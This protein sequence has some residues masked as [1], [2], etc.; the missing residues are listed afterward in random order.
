[1]G[2]GRL[3]RPLLRA[4]GELTTRR[5]GLVLVA[6]AGLSAAA[7]A[8][9]VDLPLD[10]SFMAM[11]PQDD[12]RVERFKDATGSFGGSQN[13]LLLV[14]GAPADRDGFFADLRGR[15]ATVEEVA[16]VDDRAAA[17]ALDPT[18]DAVR[19]RPKDLAGLA[20]LVRREPELARRLTADP[21]LA[22]LLEV[23]LA[24]APR[25][26]AGGAEA[27]ELPIGPA[28]LLGGLADAAEGR[29]VVPA[30][31]L[32]GD[33]PDLDARGRLVSADGR[34]NLAVVRLAID[35]LEMEVGGTAYEGI[36]DAT[37]AV[38]AGYPD[39]RWGYAGAIPFGYEDE[40]SV[41]TRIRWIS[42][43]SLGL[44]LLLFLWVER[45]PLIALLIAVPMALGLLWTFALVRLVLGV[46]TLTSAVFA[47]LLFGLAVDFAIHLVA[48]VH[49][50]E[51][52]GEA[53]DHRAAVRAALARTG[54][55]ILTGGLTTA[56][57]FLALLAGRQP[58]AR[59]LGFTTGVG[60]L[61]SLAA[62]LVVLPAL[63]ALA[64]RWRAR[65][66]GMRLPRLDGWVRVCL[67]RPR[68]VAG[69]V[70]ALTATAVA[71]IP[72][73]R[74]EYDIEAMATRGT[75]AA[76]VGREV[77]ERFGVSSDYGLCVCPDLATAEEVAAALRRSEQVARVEA[78]TDVL[79]TDP[80]AAQAA[81]D[82][83]AAALRAVGC[84]A[85][86]AAA[87]VLEPA[88]LPPA[89]LARVAASADAALGLAAAF[90]PAA[91]G[92]ARA[93]LTDFAAAARRLKAACAED[94]A[95]AAAGLGAV[96]AAC[97]WALAGPLR[98]LLAG[99]ARP[100]TPA[101]LPQALRDKF[102]DDRGRT[103][104]YAQP[105]ESVLDGERIRAFMED[106]EAACPGGATGLPAMAEIFV[107]E[108]MDD[109]PRCLA[110][111][112][113]LVLLLLLV[114]L[115]RPLLVL[116]TFLPLAAAATLAFGLVVASGQTLSVIALGGLPLI[117]GI[118]V[119]DGVHLVH[120]SV[121]GGDVDLVAGLG[122][123]GRAIL[124]TSLTTSI[125]FGGLLLM[126]HAGIEALGLL[127]VAGVAFCFLTSVSL[128]PA[129]L[130]L[131]GLAS[132]PEPD[133]PEVET[134]T[135][136]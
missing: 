72:T 1:M 122:S 126:N 79:P 44:V 50:E 117:F 66:R 129:A 120:R 80:A 37:A 4:I 78:A 101:D 25:A 90:A 103:V 77:Q 27:A 40:R 133:A 136:G 89:D 81:L 47:I 56:C 96:D 15:L 92:E 61:A 35:G 19:A 73:A 5:P 29:A 39:L 75:Q 9:V 62:M 125:S 63:L 128:F 119:D 42:L 46:V 108:A 118:G 68:L 14:E 99:A 102:F 60:L 22:T 12:P 24:A 134:P 91:E 54:P 20:D 114:D 130:A 83:V 131:L 28:E 52:G 26:A 74:F 57:A 76:E 65:G 11:L 53:P 43:A 34:A 55:G 82:E 2:P 85:P 23:L 84:E 8:A 30:G 115:R 64:G 97:R 86:P 48:R 45:S 105:R 116:V 112:A 95:R 106:L 124:L 123:V 36:R 13:L 7:V 135:G 41:L 58:S 3:T 100:P 10:A 31:L 71:V 49:D 127:V 18:G 67:R 110:A 132:A 21:G 93:E 94:P 16:A 87:G 104:V 109:V 107:A 121:E 59:H 98:A 38:A 33:G 113:V 51:A 111:A 17:L 88:P 32:G 70:L 6:A 69:G